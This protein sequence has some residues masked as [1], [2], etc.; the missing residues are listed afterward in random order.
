VLDVLFG[1]LSVEEVPFCHCRRFR[2]IRLDGEEVAGSEVVR[3]VKRPEEEA[4][5]FRAGELV[6]VEEVACWLL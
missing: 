4:R 1:R 5:S 3:H 6:I 2:R